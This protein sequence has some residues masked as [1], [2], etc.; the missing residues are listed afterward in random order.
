MQKLEVWD[1]LVVF[2]RYMVLPG[3]SD[4]T[5][6]KRYGPRH[7]DHIEG[8]GNDMHEDEEEGN[9][10]RLADVSSNNDVQMRV[11]RGEKK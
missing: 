9:E 3:N 8:D 2:L 10:T 5:L 11:A 6:A 1:Q 7:W 4:A